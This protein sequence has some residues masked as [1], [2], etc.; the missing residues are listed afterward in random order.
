MNQFSGLLSSFVAFVALA[1]P[2]T[3]TGIP[4]AITTSE[5]LN[6]KTVRPARPP[7]RRSSIAWT[8]CAASMRS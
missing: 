5:H 2:H 6:L 7:P 3:A 8:T 1:L 4:P